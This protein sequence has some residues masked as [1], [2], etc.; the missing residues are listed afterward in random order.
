MPSLSLPSSVPGANRTVR[1]RQTFLIERK[2]LIT[3]LFFSVT[4]QR[5]VRGAMLQHSRGRQATIPEPSCS[6]SGLKGRI[7]NDVLDLQGQR[8]SATVSFQNVPPSSSNAGNPCGVGPWF[9]LLIN[10]FL[11]KST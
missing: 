7:K 8:G 2:S 9:F 1:I 5:G 6:Y 11:I 3:A 10:V 4:V